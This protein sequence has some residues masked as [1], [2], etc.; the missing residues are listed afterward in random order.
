MK[1]AVASGHPRTLQRPP[2]PCHVA[3][4]RRPCHCHFCLPPGWGALSVI[5]MMV[6]WDPTRRGIG[7][8]GKAAGWTQVLV[9]TQVGV[10]HVILMS[11]QIEL[12]AQV[13]RGHPAC[14][15]GMA[16]LAWAC[17]VSSTST[18]QHLYSRHGGMPGCGTR[19]VL[20]ILDF[21]PMLCNLV[22]SGKI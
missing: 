13:F 15:C 1:G 10:L 21:L 4:K 5:H 19:R 20:H 3:N 2:L 22:P 6:H 8:L 11:S 16:L 14:K 17:S 12:L 7:I 18:P 9:L